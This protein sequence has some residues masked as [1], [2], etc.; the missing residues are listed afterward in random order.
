[1]PRPPIEKTVQNIFDFYTDRLK[2]AAGDD[3]E[4][5]RIMVDKAK[6]VAAKRQRSGDQN[7]WGA[8]APALD[9]WCKANGA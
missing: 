6:S 5:A 1:V 9:A 4:V 2:A 3:R 8:R 7:A